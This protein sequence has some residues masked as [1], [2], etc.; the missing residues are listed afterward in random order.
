M[1]GDGGGGIS[2]AELWSA[3]QLEGS[4]L[5]VVNVVGWIFEMRKDERM[6]EIAGGRRSKGTTEG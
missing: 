2:I 3:G 1:R 4:C 5:I 6:A